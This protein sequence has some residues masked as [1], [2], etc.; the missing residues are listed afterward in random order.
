MGRKKATRKRRR[1]S[2]DDDIQIVDVRPGEPIELDENSPNS[3]QVRK[4]R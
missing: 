2:I 4:K 3:I 1:I